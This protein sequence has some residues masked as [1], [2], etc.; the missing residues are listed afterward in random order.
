MARLIH[1]FVE[2]FDGYDEIIVPSASRGGLPS[3]AYE[4]A[5]DSVGDLGL[6]MDV[7]GIASRMHELTKYLTDRMGAPDLGAFFPHRVAYHRA[8]RGLRATGPGERPY[9]L[10]RQVK[11]ID[12]VEFSAHGECGDFPTPGGGDDGSRALDTGAHVVVAVES[13][14]LLH[15]GTWSARDGRA[16]RNLHVVEIL[17]RAEEDGPL[18]GVPLS[19]AEVAAA[20]G[21]LGR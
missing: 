4:V 2:T 18:D 9:E 6:L 13:S 10:L 8:C 21:L 19:G 14:C 11:G 16:M 1:H 12:L 7:Q 17:A 5:A 20:S 3:E 15:T